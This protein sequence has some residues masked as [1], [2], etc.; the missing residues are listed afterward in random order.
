M[1]WA[2]QKDRSGTPQIKTSLDFDLQKKLEQNFQDMMELRSLD[3]PKINGSIIVIHVPTGELHAMIGSRDYFNEGIDGAV[4]GSVALR[5]P[6]SALKPFTYFAAFSKGFQPD[7]EILDT[8]TS[9]HASGN[10]STAYIPQNF[11]RTFHGAVTI[12]EALA[13]SYNVP[14]VITLNEIGLSY[15]HDILKKFGFTT[16]N[17]P[18]SHYGLSVTLG[19]GEVTLLELTNAY[20]ALARGGDS[21]LP[22]SKIYAEMVT[23]ILSDPKARLKT[24]GWNESM[25]IEGIE[26]AVKTGTSYDLRDNWTLGYND[27]YAVGV[28]IGHSD[29]TPLNGTTGATGAAPIWHAVMES[30]RKIYCAPSAGLPL[31]DHLMGSS[32]NGP[33]AST[34]P[35]PLPADPHEVPIALADGLL[36]EHSKSPKPGD[37]VLSNSAKTWRV[38]SPLANACYRV[39]P[40]IPKEHQ[41]IPVKIEAE[42]GSL[43]AWKSYLDGVTVEWID[44]EEGSH[45]LYVEASDGSHQTVL[46]HIVKE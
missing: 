12:K 40:F 31:R 24:F 15:Y 44:G 7:T 16:L 27:Q 19:S 41:K 8:P 32:V 4:N 45:E 6:G 25:T 3:D 22:N 9:F 46:F 21:I 10:E 37:Q 20:A 30:L 38:V 17:K 34:A 33:S 14:A 35:F 26:T 2:S 11:D 18:Y 13:N 43:L 23:Q 39:S 1:E 36:Q 42:E 29:G 28:W 5:Q